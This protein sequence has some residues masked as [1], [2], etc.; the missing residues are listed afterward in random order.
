MGKADLNPEISEYLGILH[1]VSCSCSGYLQG[2]EVYIALYCSI[3]IS[4][5]IE[6]KTISFENQHVVAICNQVQI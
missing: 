3:E 2:K 1:F 6:I 5:K 4:G